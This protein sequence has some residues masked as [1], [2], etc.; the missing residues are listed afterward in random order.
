MSHEVD[1]TKIKP[2]GIRFKN[3]PKAGDNSFPVTTFVPRATGGI[4]TSTSSDLSV[5]VLIIEPQVHDTVCP[6]TTDPPRL[7]STT[8][9]AAT[10]SQVHVQSI[11]IEPRVTVGTI[12]TTTSNVLVS[13]PKLTYNKLWVGC[14]YKIRDL[15]ISSRLAVLV[16]PN[17]FTFQI[18]LPEP[19]DL[20][21]FS[22]Q[23]RC[24]IKKVC[25]QVEGR[26]SVSLKLISE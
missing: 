10:E 7:P 19:L 3:Y 5:Q 18:T 26:K 14:K 25:T 24:F 8:A 17:N 23:K 11:L 6:N 21:K 15:N 4:Q 9:S 13:L 16:G 20:S 1:G 2:K 12:P 22:K